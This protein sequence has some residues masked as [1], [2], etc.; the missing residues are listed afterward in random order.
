[1]KPTVSFSKVFGCKV[2]T[3]IEKH[4]RTKFDTTARDG[5]FLGFSDN[6]KT[7]NIGIDKGNGTLKTIKTRRAKFDEE[8]Y[9]AKP[10][11]EQKQSDT[12]LHSNEPD[13]SFSV[14]KSE[15]LLNAESPKQEPRDIEEALETPEWIA[16]MEKEHNSL[17]S[18]KVW[19]Q[20]Q[21]PN[22]TKPLKGKWHFA[23]KYNADGT[24]NKYKARFVVRFLS[25][26]RC[27]VQ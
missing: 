1:M 7:Y 16:A 4:F 6:R 17:Q 11:T 10:G 9:F 15:Q 19:K 3:F 8:V 26:R 23:V 13:L 25:E 5:V 24:F 20:E 27:G 18:N 12:E 22:G 21:L 2:Y 14:T